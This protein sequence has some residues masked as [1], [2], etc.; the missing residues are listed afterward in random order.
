MKQN[1][2]CNTFR[3]AINGPLWPCAYLAP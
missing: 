2:I 3:F 1:I